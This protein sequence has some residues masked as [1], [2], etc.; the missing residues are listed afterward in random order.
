VVGFIGIR[1]GNTGVT[2]EDFHIAA[3]SYGQI[4]FHDKRSSDS[5]IMR[6]VNNKFLADK[7]FSENENLFICTD[8]VFLNL[9]NQKQKNEIDDT[10]LLFQKLYQ[11]Y[12]KN[13][14]REFKGNFS[15]L[16]IDKK[17][18][19]WHIFTDHIG[20][21]NLFYFFD[22]E[23]N[24]FVFGSD[25]R[26][27][28][29]VLRQIGYPIKFS[30]LGAYFLLTFGFM[31]EDYTLI[32]GIKKLPPGSILT[33]YE[34]Q[35]SIENYFTL[36]STPYIDDN[37]KIIIEKLDQLFNDAIILEYSKDL[38]YNYSHIATLSGGLDS[39]MNVMCA[40]KMGFNNILCSTFSQNDYLDEKIAKQIASDNNMEFLFYSLNNGNF[41]KNIDDPVL[42]NDGLILY[43][44]SSHLLHNLKHINFDNLGLLHTG[45]IGD[46][47]LG[48][49]LDKKLHS[50]ISNGHIRQIAYSTKLIDRIP[51][52]MLKHCSN[53]ENSELFA[54]YQRCVNGV[55]NGYRVCE[56]FTEYSSP[57]LDKDFLQFA[58]K[59]HP[60]YRYNEDIYFKWILTKHPEAARYAWE[61]TN[62]KIG[63]NR[64]LIL[65]KKYFKMGKKKLFGPRPSDSMNP[66]DYW[67]KSNP[68]LINDLNVYFNENL[69]LLN[70]YKQL[71]EDA[72]GLYLNGS[73]V[74]KAQ[75]LTLLSAIKMYSSD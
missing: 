35:I 65:I 17:L 60:K 14:I 45:M 19:K 9:R 68:S 61:K 10:F 23:Q 56:Q 69:H 15:G 47:I 1:F 64:L 75:V 21:K 58:M 11:D 62:L 57:F 41:L 37:E 28:V 39:R 46:L 59:I 13:F 30:E 73:I 20:S 2:G 27:I 74:E 29:T 26:N 53:Y 51:Q 36:T 55:F 42:I 6:Y 22:S 66:E 40:K 16:I 32:E 52:D 70:N 43:S 44:G 72:I 24:F 33:Y 3:K 25:L 67:I 34:D 8:G 12:G 54:F 7:L 4:I 71:R 49:Y 50:E 18:D 63:A 5:Y 38:E 31:L 48:S